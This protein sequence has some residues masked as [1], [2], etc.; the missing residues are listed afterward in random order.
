MIGKDEN[1]PSPDVLFYIP[2]DHVIMR[3]DAPTTALSRALLETMLPPREP[4]LVRLHERYAV[5]GVGF[6]ELGPTLG[7]VPRSCEH[8]SSGPTIPRPSISLPFPRIRRFDG[9][10]GRCLSSPSFP[11][12]SSRRPLP[13]SDP[14]LLFHGHPEPTN[15]SLASSSP[16]GRQTDPLAAPYHWPPMHDL[17]TR[18]SVRAAPS[19]TVSVHPSRARSPTQQAPASI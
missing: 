8:P 19:G 3:V 1:R 14:V 16:A 17:S 12:S 9:A 18:R 15:R 6:R 13:H 11:A 2:E 4:S 10:I 7:N 5:A